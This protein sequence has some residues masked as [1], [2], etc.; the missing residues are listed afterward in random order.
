MPFFRSFVVAIR[1]RRIPLRV[2][3]WDRP[4]A[5]GGVY[6]LVGQRPME[7][8]LAPSIARP[9]CD[10][11]PMGALYR[12]YAHG[13]ALRQWCT[14]RLGAWPPRTRPASSRPS[15]AHPPDLAGEGPICACTCRATNF[16]AATSTGCSPCLPSCR[17]V[18]ADLPGQPGLSTAT[19]PR[20]DDASSGD[21]VAEVIGPACIGA[22]RRVVLMGHSRGPHWPSLPAGA[23]DLLVLLSPRR[24][25][26]GES[27]PSLPGAKH[28]LVVR[29][30]SDDPP[31]SSS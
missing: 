20:D 23:V 9:L 27:D 13:S 16:N 17:V 19:R 31:G 1:R 25:D 11:G 28:G 8:L 10:D 2:S 15:W 30:S 18:C 6:R 22:R 26:T 14:D 29:P 5:S 21:W 24:A 12:S 4:R 7:F 3:R